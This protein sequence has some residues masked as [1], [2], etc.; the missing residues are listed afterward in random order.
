MSRSPFGWD[1]PPGAE[2]DPRAPYN[3]RFDTDEEEEEYQRRKE[4]AEAERYDAW[5]DRMKDGE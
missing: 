5:R 1:Y 4:E 3:Q 2:N